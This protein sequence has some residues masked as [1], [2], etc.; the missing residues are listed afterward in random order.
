MR[1]LPLLLTMDLQ[2]DE[3]A[4]YLVNYHIGSSLSKDHWGPPRLLAPQ[5]SA[6]GWQAG[7]IPLLLGRG[8]ALEPAEF[9]P[10]RAGARLSLDGRWLWKPH[11]QA[12]WP[13]PHR[14][15]QIDRKLQRPEVIWSREG[16]EIL[17]LQ[18]D[19]EGRGLYFAVR[20]PDQRGQLWRWCPSRRES[21]VLVDHPEFY[22]IEFAVHPSGAGLAYVN[23]ND[24]QLYYHP[25]GSQ[26]QRRLNQPQ[27]EEESSDAPGVYR[28]SPAF[29][30]D[31][32]RFFYCTAFLEMQGGQLCNSGNLYVTAMNGGKL[33]RIGLGDHCPINLCLPSRQAYSS[34]AIAS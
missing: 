32:S 15:V 14:I 5:S 18:L 33:R 24:D 7:G 30:P 28:C 19:E 26:A 27:R 10:A 31:G 1:N 20:C 6:C 17:D 25:F 2:E 11:P 8:S 22:P 13:A 21:Q 23:Q 4:A 12:A 34:L 9:L 3:Y 16:W 29:S